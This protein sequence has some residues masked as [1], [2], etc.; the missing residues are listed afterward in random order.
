[1]CYATAQDTIG[2]VSQQLLEDTFSSL[3]SADPQ[4][5]TFSFDATSLSAFAANPSTSSSIISS[6]TSSSS[7][8]RTTTGSSSSASTT[9]TTPSGSSSGL[10]AGA[11]AGAVIGSVVGLAVILGL[12]YLAF[13]RRSSQKATTD[14][15]AFTSSHSPDVQVAHQKNFQPVRLVEMGVREPQEL[16][17]EKRH[18]LHG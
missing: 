1:M 5:T 18:E 17:A 7:A 16:P 13:R 14:E 12:A 3:S 9:T 11:I 8:A 2:N 4:A 6:S 10:S 15:A